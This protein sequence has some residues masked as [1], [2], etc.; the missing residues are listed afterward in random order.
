M[1]YETL[2]VRPLV[3]R[4]NRYTGDRP[5][6]RLSKTLSVAAMRVSDEDSSLNAADIPAQL[7]SRCEFSPNIEQND[8]ADDRQDETRRVK[9][10]TWLR[11]G[12]HASDQSPD[13][14]ATD[15]E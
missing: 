5:L 12:K 4:R 3:R 10:R 2:A 9:L 11:F 15:T 1:H 13:D 14:R 7:K 6:I 8:R